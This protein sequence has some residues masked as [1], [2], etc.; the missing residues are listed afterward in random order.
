MK[1]NVQKKLRHALIISSWIIAALGMVSLLGFV[2]YKQ[3]NLVCKNVVVKINDD[4]EHDFVDGNDILLL[5]NSKGKLI[6][7]SLANINKKLLEKIVLSNPF[8]E[9]VEVYSTLDGNLHIDAWQRDP[10]LRVYNMQNEQ[11]F[12]DKSGAFM[13]VSDKYTPSVVVANG[14]IYNTYAE[15]KIAPPPT[16]KNKENIDSLTIPR[17][18]NQV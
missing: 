5:V 4:V 10:L 18:I 13:P 17:M 7:K 3:S 14:F 9:R 12:I 16:L 11:F 1:I 8:V 2:N 15:M 6:G